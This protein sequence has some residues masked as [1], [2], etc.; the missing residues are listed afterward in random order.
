M[1][2]HLAASG[3]WIVVY[4]TI[5]NKCFYG[6]FLPQVDALSGIPGNAQ[7]FVARPRRTVYRTVNSI[8]MNNYLR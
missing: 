4:K 3:N 5:L 6:R 8:A 2:P 1:P 7:I